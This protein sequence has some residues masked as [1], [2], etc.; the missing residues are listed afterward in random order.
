MTTSVTPRE[1]NVIAMAGVVIADKVKQAAKAM[2]SFIFGLLPFVQYF[3]TI[4]IVCGGIRENSDIGRFGLN[5]CEFN[6]RQ[7]RLSRGARAVG[8]R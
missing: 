6:Y 8:K 2:E 3:S 7:E 1:A 4:E 5:S